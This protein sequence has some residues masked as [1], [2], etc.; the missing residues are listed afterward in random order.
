MVGRYQTPVKTLS[1]VCSALHFSWDRKFGI[2]VQCLLSVLSKTTKI[3]TIKSVLAKFICGSE[4]P[5]GGL[6]TGLASPASY[7]EPLPTESL[8]A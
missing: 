2:S 3:N 7:G 6:G 1:Q 5:L 8:S 4:G